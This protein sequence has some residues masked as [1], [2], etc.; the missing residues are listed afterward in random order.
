MPGGCCAGLK[1]ARAT[2][3]D[4]EPAIGA[5]DR[6]DAVGEFDIG[7]GRFEEVRGDAFSLGD[8]LVGGM[9]ERRPADRQRARAAG[10][11]AKGDHR[12][13]ALQT[14][15]LSRPRPSRSTASWA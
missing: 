10:A 3:L 14:R 7:L 6:K 11:A 8:E 12:G 5:G 4:A 2:V 15:T 1:A 9:G 13:V